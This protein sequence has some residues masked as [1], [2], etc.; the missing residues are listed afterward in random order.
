MT[1]NDYVTAL[2]Q[3]LS[4][5]VDI[6]KALSVLNEEQ[7]SLLENPELDPDDLE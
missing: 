4:K 6:L 5:K 2:K 3:G 7:K 1:E